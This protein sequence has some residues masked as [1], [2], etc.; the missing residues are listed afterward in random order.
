MQQVKTTHRPKLCVLTLALASIL[1][2]IA[3]QSAQAEDKVTVNEPNGFVNDNVTDID[4]KTEAGD[5]KITR[6]WNGQEWKVNPHWESLSTRYSN[7]TGSNSAQD[8]T[9]Y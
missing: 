3:S 1:S 5:V 4:V 6:Q 7:L 8:S 9:N 2:V